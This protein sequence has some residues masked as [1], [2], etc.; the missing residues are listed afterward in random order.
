[1]SRSGIWYTKNISIRDAALQA[2]KLFRRASDIELDNVHFSD[3]EETMWTC[4]NIKITNS[5]INED[6]FGKDSENI[7][8]DNVS[9]IGNYAFDGAKNI[10]VH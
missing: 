2:P 10:E 6:Y 7:Y 1:M 4:K 3:V 9:I 8:L 5:Q